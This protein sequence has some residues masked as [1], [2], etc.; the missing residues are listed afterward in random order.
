VILLTA[1][2]ADS[3][4]PTIVSRCQV[5]ALRPLP[6]TLVREALITRWLVP[7]ERADLLAHVSGGRLGWA[8]RLHADPDAL[9]ERA[10][11]LDDLRGLMSASRVERFAYAE[12]LTRESTTDRIRETLE[13]W[14]AFWRDVLLASAQASAPPTNPDRADDVRRVAQAVSPSTAHGVL[15]AFR[16]TSS[17]LDRNVNARLALEVLLLDWPRL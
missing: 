11:R 1:E 16:R 12:R 4:L 2:S 8:V 15:A 14:S 9:D 6:L 17:L 3:L 5:L 10:R 13:L 7:A